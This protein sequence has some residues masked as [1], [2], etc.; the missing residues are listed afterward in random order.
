M[1]QPPCFQPLELIYLPNHDLMFRFLLMRDIG[2][3]RLKLCFL[4]FQ[5]ES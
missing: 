5:D 2:L 3:S 1:P 4:C